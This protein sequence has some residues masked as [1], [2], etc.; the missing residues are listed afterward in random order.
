MQG[1]SVSTVSQFKNNSLRRGFD[2]RGWAQEQQIL[3]VSSTPRFERGPGTLQKL[4]LEI[5]DGL[6]LKCALLWTDR[7]PGAGV[8]NGTGTAIRN[9]FPTNRSYFGA[10]PDKLPK[11]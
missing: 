4:T 3:L 11:E 7:D 8:K 9:S 2:R 6:L 5:V 1:T 10:V